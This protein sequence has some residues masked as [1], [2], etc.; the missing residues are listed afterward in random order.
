MILTSLE[1][2]FDLYSN[3]IGCLIITMTVV[4]YVDFYPS[5]DVGRLICIIACIF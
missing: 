2:E 5:S 3:N 1:S 4:G